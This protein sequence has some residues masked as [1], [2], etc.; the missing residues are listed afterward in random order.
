MCSTRKH[1]RYPSSRLLAGGRA[2]KLARLFIYHD[3]LDYII[4]YIIPTDLD[5]ER[6]SQRVT[7]TLV[8]KQKL[9]KLSSRTPH[10]LHTSQRH[11]K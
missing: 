9:P 10:C 5:F 8:A 3:L 2:M 11:Q 1:T 7:V 4:L 6:E